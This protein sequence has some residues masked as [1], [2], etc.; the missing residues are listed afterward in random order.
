MRL[1]LVESSMTDGRTH[2]QPTAPEVA[3]LIVGDIDQ[4]IH[5][6]DIILQT[7]S[8]DLQRIKDGYCV[9]IQHKDATSCSRKRVRLTMRELFA[10]R[11][12]ECQNEATTLFHS[13]RL[14][15]QFI[16]NAY[17]MIESERLS[18]I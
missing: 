6:M 3:T 15:Q 2:N 10:F 8:G 4:T 14:F 16:V 17:N 12:H 1:G 9:G 7:C 11:I 5:G 18:Y 13:R